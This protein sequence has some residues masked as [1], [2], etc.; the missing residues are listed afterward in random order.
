V[1]VRI[2]KQKSDVTRVLHD[3]AVEHDR[4]EWKLRAAAIPGALI[5]AL[6]FHAW[7]TGHFLQRTF[8]SMMIHELGHTLTA[9]WCGFGAL[10]TL[11]KTII[12]E[13][14]GIVWLLVALVELGLVAIAWRTHRL[15]FALVGLALACVQVVALNASTDDAQAWIT[16]GGDGGAMVLGTLLM[17]SFFVPKLQE[18]GLRWGLLVIGAAAFVDTYATWWSARSDPDVIPFGEIEGVGLSD[19]SKLTEVYG[20]PTSQLVHRYVTLGAV[21]LVSLAAV[22]A[23]QVWR[24][25]QRPA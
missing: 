1:W 20:W 2:E 21:C 13:A 9:W 4:L 22:Y 12:P 3:G 19:P 17:A 8:L 15:V 5:V 14:R 24:S 23:W 10:P 11:W 6:A 18:H 25:R 7:P 16:F